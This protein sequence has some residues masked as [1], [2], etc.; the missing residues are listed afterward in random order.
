MNALAHLLAGWL[1]LG[2]L[3]WGVGLLVEANII[4][5]VFAQRSRGMVVAVNGAAWGLIAI[6]VVGIVLR[7]VL[8]SEVKVW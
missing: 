8:L 5:E 7:V 3:I 4:R 1:G 2:C 6:G